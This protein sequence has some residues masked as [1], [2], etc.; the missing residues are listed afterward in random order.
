MYIIKAH[1]F[2]TNGHFAFLKT[3]HKTFTKLE[4]HL[5]FQ[6]CVMPFLPNYG[7]PREIYLI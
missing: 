5:L 6:L 1:P 3:K 4:L 7:V 2:Q